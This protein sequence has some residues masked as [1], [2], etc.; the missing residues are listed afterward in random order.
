MKKTIST[1]ISLLL[2]GVTLLSIYV[3]ASAVTE[4][5]FSDV[6]DESIL[7]EPMFVDV[8]GELIPEEEYVRETEPETQATT[9][10]KTIVDRD[11]KSVYS[12]GADISVRATGGEASYTLRN[13]YRAD[14]PSTE[15]SATA[16]YYTYDDD[17]HKTKYTF[18]N[19][20]YYSGKFK[21]IVLTDG[22]VTATWVCDE[23]SLTNNAND[24]VSQGTG[25]LTITRTSSG[26]LPEYYYGTKN[27][28][29]GSTTQ[30]WAPWNGY[31]R[32]A[33]DT[34][35]VSA[36]PHEKVTKIVFA[37]TI[38]SVSNN[39]CRGFKGSL[40]NVTFNANTT[41]IGT[42]AFAGAGMSTIT[43]NSSKTIKEAAFYN[44]DN[45]TTLNFG[46]NTMTIHNPSV[47][48]SSGTGYNVGVFQNCDVLA[49]I[50]F[51][52]ATTVIP[53]SCFRACGSIN[54]ITWGAVTTI[55]A[56][57]FSSCDGFTTLTLNG[58]LSTIG[59]RAFYKC[60]G[61]FTRVNFRA[62][63]LTAT[64]VEAFRLCETLETA[65]FGSNI[66]NI[67][68]QSFYD[69]VELTTVIFDGNVLTTIGEEAFR[70]C[71]ELVYG[72]ATTKVADVLYG[73]AYH[74]SAALDVDSNVFTIPYS[75]TDIGQ[76]AFRNCYRMR[77]VA[78]SNFSKCSVSV[79]RHNTF[80]NCIGLL[81]CFLS[82]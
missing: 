64:G 79:I 45:L 27:G 6:I 24:T 31:R 4:E 36:M 54:S 33:D 11:K 1:A 50:N 28:L 52:S 81:V 68:A 66:T 39:A 71:N 14:T 29:K 80:V 48:S 9:L 22:G 5:T 43:W 10:A 41:T 60:G 53:I 59:N 35:W 69:D 77:A 76:G 63:N 55:R 20:D 44:C 65:D 42:Y 12:T 37:S 34:A 3:P 62:I 32:N 56:Y 21:K 30:V 67:S 25:T 16:K 23:S 70:N 47:D 72:K 74:I 57:A 46:S 8:N 19:G 75:V 49:T 15:Q 58:S 13:V 17:D 2:I 26:A 18:K 40:S 7:D 82:P 51:G 73:G 61:N 78:W 38:T